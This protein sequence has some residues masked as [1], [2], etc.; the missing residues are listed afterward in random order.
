MALCDGRLEAVTIKMATIKLAGCEIQDKV[1]SLCR[2]PDKVVEDK[3]VEAT[4]WLSHGRVHLSTDSGSECN[5]YARRH[6]NNQLSSIYQYLDM[7][8]KKRLQLESQLHDNE[9]DEM[10]QLVSNS[11]DDSSPL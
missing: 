3:V 8:F 1:V 10:P 11:D 5:G 7:R 4:P 2:I 6:A 9:S